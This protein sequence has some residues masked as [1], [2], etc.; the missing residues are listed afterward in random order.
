MEDASVLCHALFREELLQNPARAGL[1]ALECA[2]R[3]PARVADSFPGPFVDPVDLSAQLLDHSGAT[4]ADFHG[5]PSS[6][7][8]GDPDDARILHRAPAPV[9]SA[10]CAAREPVQGP[11]RVER[12]TRYAPPPC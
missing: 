9:K 2:G 3:G 12:D 5:L 11:S 10:R 1:L 8:S 7:V 4:A 6:P